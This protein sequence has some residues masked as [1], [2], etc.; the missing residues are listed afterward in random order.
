MLK[1]GFIQAEDKIDHIYYNGTLFNSS[2]TQS[3]PATINDV[4]NGELVKNGSDY[5]LSVIRLGIS[6][7]AL[8]IFNIESDIINPNP[9]Q[10]LVPPYVTVYNVSLSYHGVTNTSPVIFTPMAT[11]NQFDLFNIYT[12]QFFLDCINDAYATCYDLFGGSLS[13]IV[14]YPPFLYYDG[15]SNLFSLF[16]ESGYSSA[17]VLP[18]NV[19]MNRLLFDFFDSFDFLLLNDYNTSNGPDI[20]FNITSS[21]CL[22]ISP[23]PPGYPAILS[24][25]VLLAGE[26]LWQMKQ[27][28]PSAYSWNIVDSLV[29]TSSI[30]T[31]TENIPFSPSGS[32]QIQNSSIAAITDFTSNLSETNNIGSRG[33][34]QYFPTAQY[35][36]VNITNSSRVQNISLSIQ[37][38]TFNGSLSQLYIN[39][40]YSMS[41]KLLFVKKSLYSHIKQAMMK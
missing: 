24:S 19:Y 39:P 23:L 38:I 37:Y 41:I 8:P 25:Y 16:I 30:G 13:A 20:Q 34:L 9:G 10:P 26:S 32:L 12:Y 27:Q 36:L 31:N 28:Y 35:R 33:F 4:L 40:R 17:S 15:A 11:A 6:G 1:S 7:H 14:K 3:I 5:Y 22:N 29:V 18:V 2:F 21:T